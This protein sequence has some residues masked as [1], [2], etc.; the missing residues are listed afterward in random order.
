MKF[1][2]VLCCSFNNQKYPISIDLDLC[3]LI[4]LLN[5]PMTV[6]F[7]IFIGVAGCGRPSYV[8][9][10]LITFAS[11]AFKNNAPISASIADDAMCFRITRNEW[12]GPL[13]NGYTS[14]GIDQREK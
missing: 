14:I 10:S 13:K 12:I 11:L 5:I 2:I 6:I 4:S 7:S 9:A 1:K 8:N 3:L